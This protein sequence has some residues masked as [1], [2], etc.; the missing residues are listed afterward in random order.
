MPKRRYGMGASVTLFRTAPPGMAGKVLREAGVASSPPV[1]P[2]EDAVPLSQP[3]ILGQD[4][5]CRSWGCIW[6][7]PGTGEASM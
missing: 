4:P 7:H 3:G 2:A 1:K 5:N 6:Q